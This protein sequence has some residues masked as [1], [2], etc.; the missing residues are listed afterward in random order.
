MV[1][2]AMILH[3]KAILRRGQPELMMNFVMNHALVQDPSLD[4][5]TSSPACY[6]CTTDVSQ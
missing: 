5:L 6:H 3:C 4:L 1:F 2:Q